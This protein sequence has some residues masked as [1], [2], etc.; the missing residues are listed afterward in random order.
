[1]KPKDNW[2][3]LRRQAGPNA[4]SAVLWRMRLCEDMGAEWAAGR[5]LLVEAYLEQL[6]ELL[7]DAEAL[8][9][10]LNAE[11]ELRVAYAAEVAA[12]EYESRLRHWV[13]NPG[14]Q[15]VPARLA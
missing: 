15:V 13:P 6:P 12:F 11:D 1:M 5:P 14:R 10:L 3:Q 9:A 8:Q 4:A 2:D 7:E